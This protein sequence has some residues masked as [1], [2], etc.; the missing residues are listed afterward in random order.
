MSGSVYLT[1]VGPSSRVQQ[2]QEQCGCSCVQ[3]RWQDVV[4]SFDVML[5]RQALVTPSPGCLA[6]ALEACLHLKSPGACIQLLQRASAAGTP[7]NTQSVK[8]ALTAMC[9][10][11]AWLSAWELLRA[12]EV[13]GAADLECTRIFA[14]LLAGLRQEPEHAQRPEV[15][16]ALDDLVDLVCSACSCD[17]SLGSALGMMD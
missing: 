9:Q 14:E 5:H 4:D 2:T 11:R 10:M 3:S 17:A 7:L 15:R 13:H 8:S 12:A 16:A 6:I 1:L